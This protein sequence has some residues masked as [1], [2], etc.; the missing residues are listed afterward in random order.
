M[1]LSENPL[2]HGLIFQEIIPAI[3]RAAGNFG[4]GVGILSNLKITIS[5]VLAYASHQ[6]SLVLLHLATLAARKVL[7]AASRGFERIMNHQLKIGV[8][9][10]GLRVTRSSRFSIHSSPVDRNGHAFDDNFLPGQS[11][12]DANVEWVC[13]SCDGG[14]GPQWPRG[15]R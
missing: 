7:D 13:P 5:P 2:L 9:R 8:R 10:L 6:N 1:G 14:A 15:T 12:V 3:L 11:Q 4:R